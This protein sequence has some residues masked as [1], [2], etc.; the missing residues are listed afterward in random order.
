VLRPT[1]AFSPVERLTFAFQAP[2]LRK[3]WSAVTDGYPP[4]VHTNSGLG[5]ADV[6]IRYRLLSVESHTVTLSAGS[7]LPTGNNGLQADG[8]RLDE[9]AQLGIGAVAPFAAAAYELERGLW[10]GYATA[11]LRIPLTNTWDF[12]HG[13][14]YAGEL[15]AMFTPWSWLR[16]GLGLEARYT[17]QNLENRRPQPNSGGFVLALT[18]ALMFQ[19]TGTLSIGVGGQIPALERLNGEQSVGPSLNVGVHYR[20]E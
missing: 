18:P 3:R 5:D 16:V 7:S 14:A 6:G 4:T 17:S 1:L 13:A 8:F 15:R 11:A 9:H 19:P 2:V 12:R 10:A 20:V